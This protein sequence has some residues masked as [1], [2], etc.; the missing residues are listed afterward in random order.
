MLTSAILAGIGGVTALGGAIYGTIASSKAN[1]K[2]RQLIQQQRNDNREWYNTRMA[3]DYTKRADV[4]AAI[5]RQRELLNDQY[6]QAA[7]TNVVSGGTQEALSLQQEAANRGVAQTMTD[8]AAQSAAHKQGIEN[9]Y[10]AQ[11]AALDQQQAQSYQQQ[12]AAAAQ[13]ASQ[14]ANAGVELMGN[15]VS[16]I[17]VKDK[18]VEA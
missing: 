1:N 8:V 4:Q 10:R 9:S 14:V 11:D 12:A 2:A 17:P 7:A 5:N 16:K 6:K 13:A 15:E 3:E 18:K